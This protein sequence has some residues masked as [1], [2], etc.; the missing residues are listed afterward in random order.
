MRMKNYEADANLCT[1]G[2]LG[3]FKNLR[4]LTVKTMILKDDLYKKSI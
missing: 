3:D 1:L 2:I 4:K